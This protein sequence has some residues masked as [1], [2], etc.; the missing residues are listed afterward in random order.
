M[1]DQFRMMKKRNRSI[2]DGDLLATTSKSATEDAKHF[3]FIISSK[4][5]SKQVR[6]WPVGSNGLRARSCFAAILAISV[7]L[8][9]PF[10]FN[11]A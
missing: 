11:S 6:Y 8:E 3:R 4:L 5:V 1:L 2:V 7:H 9:L 10:I